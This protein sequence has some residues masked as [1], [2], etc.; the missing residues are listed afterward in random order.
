MESK[1]KVALG[2]FKVVEN[3][4]ENVESCLSYMK[5][6]DLY[7]AK[8]LLLPE[9]ILARDITDPLSIL[10]SAQLLDG[11]FMQRVLEA[12]KAL[13]ITTVFTINIPGNDGKVINA[14]IAVKNG[15]IIARYDKLHLYDAFSVQESLTVQEGDRIAPLLEIEGFKFGLM[16]CYDLRF[17]ELARSLALQGA[18]AFLLPSAWVKGPQKEHHWKVLATARALENTCYM[19]AVSECGVINIGNSLIVDPLGVVI[20][21]L[22]EMPGLLFGEL[23][24]ERLEMA[25]AQLPVLQNTR[26]LPPALK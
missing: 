5:E 3:W 21:Q 13:T 6:A 7:G 2:Q 11:P 26:F 4:E 20:G 10:K 12:S 23:D 17:P 14:L 24:R 1:L 9:A 25:R 19:L 8:L 15:E 16:T 18:D 22:S